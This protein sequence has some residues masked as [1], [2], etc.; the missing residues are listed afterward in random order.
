[1]PTG[2]LSNY[3]EANLLDHSVGTSA[4]TAPAN[5]YLALFTSDPGDDDSGTE[6]SGGDY[7]R[8][9]VT[10]TAASTTTDITTCAN[11]ADVEF[12]EAT[13]SWG[14]VSHIGVYDADDE[15]N[16]LWHGEVTVAKAIGSGDTA[17][18]REG[19]LVLRLS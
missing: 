3:L 14:T 8:V 10:F 19:D 2:S 12:A 6:V 17:I 5:V 1:M 18:I 16:L 15:G 13:A 7:A 11:V 4:F 9:I